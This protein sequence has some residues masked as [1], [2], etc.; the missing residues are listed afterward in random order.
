MIDDLHF[1]D[2]DDAV[3]ASL[4]YFLKELPASVRAVLASRRLPKL[5]L[6]RLRARA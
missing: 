3:M 2:D 4:S 5:P 1:V 6:D